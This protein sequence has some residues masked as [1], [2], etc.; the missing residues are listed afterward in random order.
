MQCLS[1][2]STGTPYNV[3]YVGS[4]LGFVSEPD[5]KCTSLKWAFPGQYTYVTKARAEGRHDTF[6]TRGGAGVNHPLPICHTNTFPLSLP[7]LLSQ[8]S[9]E[10]TITITCQ[11]DVTQ[12]APQ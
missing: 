8:S 2:W 10:L 5:L 7:Y 6:L 1:I 3:P 4:T 12:L 11:A 9:T